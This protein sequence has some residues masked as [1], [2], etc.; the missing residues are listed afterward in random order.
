MEAV[1]P[2]AP[3]QLIEINDAGEFRVG[4]EARVALQA[5]G[6]GKLCIVA[7]AGLYR[8][9]KS[10][11]VNYLLD[12]QG[13]FKVGPTV[14]RCTR[15]I[16]M[17]GR[18]KR[19]L[20]QNGE[21]CWV[22]L[23]D[24]E[25]LGGLEADSQYDL[26]IFSL[27]TLLCSTLVY[28]SLGTI[29][30]NAI[31][32]LS[33]VAQLT[34]A[35]R[36]NPSEGA[37]E[38]DNEMQAME[39]VNYF[40]SFAW[41]LRDFSLDLVDE[42][43]TM[44]DPDEYLESALKP[45]VGFD[46]TTLERNRIRQML[47]AF[48]S[49]R[50]CFP[51]VRPLSDEEQLQE[52][53]KVPYEELRPEFRDGLEELK[54]YLYFHHLKPKVVNNVA[55][56]GSSFIAL[57]EQ[58]ISAICEGG[59][60]TIT[61]A[62]EEVMQQECE[63]ACD[64]A[65]E[66]YDLEIERQM[67]ARTSGFELDALVD[68]HARALKM[69]LQV[70]QQ[71]AGG[72][73][74][75]AYQERVEAAL[76]ERFNRLAADNY[77]RSEKQ[78]LSTLNSLHG[79]LIAPKLVEGS[80]GYLESIDGPFT[81]LKEDL[82]VL[83][84]SYQKSPSTAGPAKG[85]VL[86]AFYDN[87]VLEAVRWMTQRLEEEHEAKVDD[88]QA[89]MAVVQ[90]KLASVEAREKVYNT[91][92]EKQRSDVLKLTT[93]NMQLEQQKAAT[94]NRMKTMSGELQETKAKLQESEL[95]LEETKDAYESEHHWQS[96]LTDKLDRLQRAHDEKHA[97][98]VSLEAAHSDHTKTHEEMHASLTGRVGELENTLS[99]TTTDLD[100][101]L[102]LLKVTKA[103]LTSKE[104]QLS[105]LQQQ[106]NQLTVELTS[107]QEDLAK[108]TELHDASVADAAQLKETLEKQLAD[109]QEQS[110][111]DQSVAKEA[112][113]ALQQRI[114]E[115]SQNLESKIAE[116]KELDS[117]LRDWQTRF[118]QQ[119]KS[120]N[121]LRTANQKKIAQLQSVVERHKTDH[122][123]TRN[124]LQVK[125]TKE[126]EL[127]MRLENERQ[128][129]EAMQSEK[130]SQILALQKQ[131]TDKSKM[132]K[133]AQVKAEQLKA[134]LDEKDAE[135]ISVQAEN[136]VLAADKDNA[137]QM[138]E[139]SISEHFNSLNEKDQAF[140]DVTREY[141]QY[142]SEMEKYR[143]DV[144][145]QL[146]SYREIMK[147]AMKKKEGMLRKQTRG[148]KM[149]SKWHVKFITLVGS[150]IFYRDP[151]TSSQGDKAFQMKISTTVTE[152]PS[153]S[154]AFVVRTEGDPAAELALRAVDRESMNEWI[155]A[156]NS[157]LEAE[158]SKMDQER[159]QATEVGNIEDG[160]EGAAAEE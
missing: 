80:E 62:W 144:E 105:E 157:S 81:S 7:V 153:E 41:V 27:A 30:E 79:S 96:Q 143:G 37:G 138:W 148:R 116:N 86:A 12:L 131:A 54:E 136:S 127:E 10:S 132:L 88:V 126:R 118:A 104:E 60:P 64:R 45:Q 107:T 102:E 149:F 125:T 74:S 75:G 68:V 139:A 97:K 52:I 53:D 21:T 47:C 119:E 24:T 128:N 14:A 55:V 106:K 44:M 99:S 150:T 73:N 146:E 111:D 112:K 11:L 16:W 43:G 114:D 130:D 56:N 95:E 32:S 58:Y 65:L 9:G 59:V 109:L 31:T 71:R 160:A 159:A 67:V 26:R 18:P 135:L 129:R 19:K 134:K 17:W 90:Q 77:A 72:D 100:E 121:D 151:G 4:D 70:F 36:V 46:E 66:A 50:K 110:A 40:P 103:D 23:L 34:Q 98:L 48:F 156:L 137:S 141:D 8:T 5:L 28:N 25:G 147:Q 120:T 133:A 108:Q 89:K 78:C 94:E 117:Q 33:F 158:R 92:I 15:G 38:E 22:L 39:F 35:I 83:S 113:A 123:M 152:H 6:P 140:Q 49:E 13:G 101:A 1:L 145:E 76:I 57:C 93:K 69:A 63:H 20:M 115:A 124:E 84:T 155:A 61:S 29:D 85:A 142:K 154:F 2:E 122:A 87:E 82:A 42:H 91:S 3:I 51:L